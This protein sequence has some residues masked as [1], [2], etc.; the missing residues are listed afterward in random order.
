M[1]NEEEM[2]EVVPEPTVSPTVTI[3]NKERE[4]V[5]ESPEAK[6]PE[7]EDVPTVDASNIADL[8]VAERM[9]PVLEDIRELKATVEA[10]TSDIRQS[11]KLYALMT[12][13]RNRAMLLLAKY[14]ELYEMLKALADFCKDNI[15]TE[16][17]SDVGK[18]I[19]TRTGNFERIAL[20]TL[21]SFGVAPIWP[22]KN[23]RFDASVHQCIATVAPT[24]PDDVPG[25]ISE[26][27]KMGVLQDGVVLKAA[28]VIVFDVPSAQTDETNA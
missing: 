3:E 5:P 1:T 11:L 22:A 27:S 15:A 2:P 7:L 6:P 24:S 13:S 8:I 18:R 20:R 28:D 16:T 25:A 23:E 17:C 19:L 10:T 9:S 4:K 21:A 14:T 26:C 12:E